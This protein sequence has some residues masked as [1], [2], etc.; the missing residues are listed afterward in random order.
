[1]TLHLSD[2][3]HHSINHLTSKKDLKYYLSDTFTG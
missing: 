3:D 2:E 1:M